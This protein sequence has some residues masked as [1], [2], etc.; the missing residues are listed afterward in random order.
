MA[1]DA[2]T[3]DP[4][5][6]ERLYRQ[7]LVRTSMGSRRSKSGANNSNV[8]ING[9]CIRIAK[10]NDWVPMTQSP[11][12]ESVIHHL[13]ENLRGDVPSLLY[14]DPHGRFMIQKW[15]QV[16][17]LSR[18]ATDPGTRRQNYDRIPRRYFERVAHL[19][20]RIQEIPVVTPADAR[21]PSALG[22]MLE[23][24][25]PPDSNPPA[26]M[27]ATHAEYNDL[28]ARDVAARFQMIREINPECVDYMAGR[29]GYP[30][31]PERYVESA[32]ENMA[33]T[34]LALA[35]ADLHSQ[36]LGVKNGRDWEPFFFDLESVGPMPPCRAV[37]T[38]IVGGDDLSESKTSEII[39]VHEQAAPRHLQTNFRRDVQAWVQANAIQTAIQRF[40]NTVEA[41]ERN[42]GRSSLGL[43]VAKQAPW[44][45]F[46]V[47]S[48]SGFWGAPRVDEKFVAD[49]L[50]TAA[51]IC[52]SG[53]KSSLAVAYG[54]GPALGTRTTLAVTPDRRPA[55]PPAQRYQRA[56][57][58]GLRLS[59]M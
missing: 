2:E 25:G 31:H 18:F 21:L 6:A 37:A 7:A 8:P 35:H 46:R 45:A 56:P 47:N 24:F 9:L 4:R 43:V 30:E 40:Q 50:R 33:E 59:R 57:T 32:L 52:G 20:R 22:T 55:P 12:S 5:D 26:H 23:K 38:V 17:Q 44:L 58:L 11:Y 19:W 13:L 28:V 48:V 1:A 15:E 27:P 34:P 39:A 54:F 49:T 41:V 42:A 14:T 3:I 51:E 29:F 10:N 53:K 36:N 16:Q